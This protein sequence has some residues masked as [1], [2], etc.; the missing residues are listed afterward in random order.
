MAPRVRARQG[1]ASQ[2]AD[3]Q[4]F[5]AHHSQGEEGAACRELIPLFRP[6]TCCTAF[7]SEVL[8]TVSIT[9]PTNALLCHCAAAYGL[10][11][12]EALEHAWVGVQH[13]R[14]SQRL[15]L[16]TSFRSSPPNLGSLP[17]SAMRPGELPH[18]LLERMR[19][20]AHACP[21]KRAAM[22]QV[23]HDRGHGRSARW[24]GNVV[25][26]SEQSIGGGGRL[27]LR[28]R[29]GGLLRSPNNLCR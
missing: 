27:A 12:Q 15:G 14:S 13:R 20:Y 29:V 18:V 9:T 26:M 1:P 8:G 6:C 4:T 25:V 5:R 11:L 7:E 10:L 23:G 19:T 22:L 28:C 21:L 17:E 3:D 2:A 16:L 24:C